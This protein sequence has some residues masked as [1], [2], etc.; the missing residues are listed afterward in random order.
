MTAQVPAVSLG[1][2]RFRKSLASQCEVTRNR[3]NHTWRREG[4]AGQAAHAALP[5]PGFWARMGW[6]KV[7]LQDIRI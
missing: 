6:R 5:L 1:Y 4:P 3:L 7:S 2:L